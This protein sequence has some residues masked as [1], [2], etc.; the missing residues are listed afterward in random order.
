MRKDAARMLQAGAM[1]L[2][3]YN[4]ASDQTDYVISQIGSA[5]HLIE[6]VGIGI[7]LCIVLAVLIYVMHMRGWRTR[8]PYTFPDNFGKKKKIA[9]EGDALA[10]YQVGELLRKKTP[11]TA[12]ERQQ[13]RTYF[14]RARNL[15]FTQARTHDPFAHFMLGEIYRQKFCK[16]RRP[17]RKWYLLFDQ[18]DPVEWHYYQSRVLYTEKIEHKTADAYRNLAILNENGW[19]GDS[20]KVVALDN[21]KKAADL[22]DF[23]SQHK[24]AHMLY[25]DCKPDEAVNYYLLAAK[26]PQGATS[27]AKKTQVD[28]QMFL[29]DIYHDGI[30]RPVNFQEAYFW[31]SIAASRG[32][33]E[34]A[35]K[36]QILDTSLETKHKLAIQERLKDFHRH[37][38]N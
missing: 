3:R 38:Q 17:K 37:L 20:N 15:F 8:A 11:Q 2:I 16:V 6:G 7:S 13:S 29:G 35:G 24:A 32:K 12:L 28:I 25:A 31:Y 5:P 19:G 14:L 27:E 34:A 23:F 22:S 9:D 21:Y 33:T 1:T 26:N 18:F 36:R 4:K 10:C 30:G